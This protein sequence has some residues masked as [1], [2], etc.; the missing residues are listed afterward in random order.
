[1]A[2]NLEFIKSVTGTSVGTLDVTDCFSADYDVYKIIISKLDND[3][4]GRT[5]LRLIDSVGSV[6]SDSEYDQAILEMSSVS[7]FTEVRDVS[8]TS[9][10]RIG[11]S[12]NNLADSIGIVTYIFNPYD[13]SSYTFI[14][15]QSTGYYDDLSSQSGQK[16]IGVHKQTEQITGIHLYPQT[17]AAT[18]D[19]ITV[20]VFG[21]K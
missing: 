7:S 4:D 18:F 1:M 9:F 3:T 2:G 20:K 10:T 16:S 8:T 17:V 12:S 11:Y 21:V 13:S 14:K 15:A 6:I 5:R 19:N